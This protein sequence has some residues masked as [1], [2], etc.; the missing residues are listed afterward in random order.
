MELICSVYTQV[1][2]RFQRGI[3]GGGYLPMRKG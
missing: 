3:I 1:S 2:N